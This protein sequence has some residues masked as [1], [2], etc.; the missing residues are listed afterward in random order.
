MNDIERFLTD[1][2]AGLSS[3][4]KTLPSRYFYDEIGDALFIQIMSLPEYYLTD[5]ELEI[6]TTKTYQLIEGLGLDPEMDFD[7]IELGPGD[8]TKTKELLKVLV[9]EGYTFT[10]RPIDISAGALDTLMKN[11]R[12]E[13]KGLKIKKHRGD[14]FRELHTLSSS[15]KPKVVLFLGSN[16]GNMYDD[17]AHAFIEQL[18]GELNP[19]DQLVLGVDLKKPRSIVL[20]AYNDSQGVTSMFNLNLLAR[21]NR[22]MGAD[23]DPDQF[24]HTPEYDENEGIARSYLTSVSDQMVRIKSLDKSFQFVKGERI[25]MEVSRKYDDRVVRKLIAD[26]ELSISGKLTDKRNYFCD[27]ILVHN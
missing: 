22:E 5:A 9:D 7:L 8:G 17:L 10:Y 15:D 14:Y 12:P 6:F 13:I 4:P 21:I 27:Y 3:D 25:L 19:G 23:F 1:V 11:L 24:L 16:I 26:T 20:P 2:D 18:S